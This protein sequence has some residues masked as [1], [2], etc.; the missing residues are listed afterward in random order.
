M[1]IKKK[2]TYRSSAYYLDLPWTY[3]VQTYKE[4]AHKNYLVCVRELPGVCS[5]GENLQEA[6]QGIKE[7]MS[8]TFELYREEGREVPEPID[9]QQYKGKIAYRTTSKRH[10]LLVNQAKRQGISLSEALDDCV[11]H[12]FKKR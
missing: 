8:A 7:A 5:D 9:E 3:M 12:M 6:M 1:A 4:G 10:F 11:D 2:S